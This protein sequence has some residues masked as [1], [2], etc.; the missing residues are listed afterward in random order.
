MKNI[1]IINPSELSRA[2][3]V[4]YFTDIL[5]AEDKFVYDYILWYRN[6][7]EEFPFG[8]RA[9]LSLKSPL[10]KIIEFYKYSRYAERIVRNGNYDKLII[11]L[12]MPAV[13]MSD[14]LVKHY[15]K[16]YILDIRDYHPLLNFG[17]FR[18]KFKAALYHASE[19]IISSPGFKNWLPD[20][21]EYTISHN[22]GDY[23]LSQPLT[24]V[25]TKDKLPINIVTVG[26]IRDYE[27]N[28]ELI[29]CLGNN[30]DYVMNYF[31]YSSVESRLRTYVKKN[32]ISNVFFNGRYAKEQ[33]L[34]LYQGASLVN[35]YSPNIAISTTNLPNRLYYS[36][37]AGIPIICT[38]GG[39]MAEYAERYN[40][41]PSVTKGDD[42]S[43]VL[44]N[45]CHDFNPDIYTKG[46][47]SLLEQIRNDNVEF[48]KVVVDFLHTKK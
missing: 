44:K 12:V 48:K 43:T 21:I 4:K 38:R 5:D 1:A 31:G 45:Y 6:E 42:F 33:E 29:A 36:L 41:G 26:Q 40:I 20:D 22:I 27:Q 32:G 39:L 7:T 3:Y 9:T 2:P 46:R 10:T 28:R 19:V 14:F 24:P 37:L 35:Y 17:L 25:T 47:D 16:R 30:P 8:Y 15:S 18:R 13:F 23:V 34:S 11:H